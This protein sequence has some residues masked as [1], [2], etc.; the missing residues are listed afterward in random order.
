MLTNPSQ[1]IIRNQDSLNQ[2]KVLVLNHEAD[3]L[4]KALLDIA[5]SVDALAL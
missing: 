5:A 1:V 3:L 2:H 4:P